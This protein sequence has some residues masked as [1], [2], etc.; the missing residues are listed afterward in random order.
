[1]KKA[2]LVLVAHGSRIKASNDEI[3][4]F[5]KLISKEMGSEFV[6]IGVGFLELAEPL[7]PEALSEAAKVMR[8]KGARVLWVYPYFLASGSHVS[9]DIPEII[10]RERTN[11]PDLTVK[12]LPYLGSKGALLEVVLS[13]VRRFQA[14]L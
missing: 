10:E 12:L 2:S 5:V 11:Y 6:H 14:D 4:E 7:I 13:Q 3:A 8:L 9:K 1:M